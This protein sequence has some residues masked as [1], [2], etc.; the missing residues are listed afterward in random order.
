MLRRL[1][2][3]FVA[4]TLLAS[5]FAAPVHAQAKKKG[6]Q[7]AGESSAATAPTPTVPDGPA[8]NILIRRTLLT[9]NDAN[10]SGNYTVLH[11]LSAP[12]FRT[13]NDPAKLASI[14]AKLR[15]SK[16]DFAPIVYFDPK[17]V[18]QPEI[19]KAG[20]LRLSGFMPTR[21]QQVNFDMLFQQVSG[22][23]RLFGIAVNTSAAKDA[24]AAPTAAAP[25]AAKS[26]SSGDPKKKGK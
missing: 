3:C 5:A 22:R 14:F 1:F 24:A 16:M 13:A 4:I 20:L 15:D 17:L 10:L 7:P 19:T 11:D 8:L 9:L 25:A 2:P 23:W 18:R 26:A 21:P 6:A 12:G